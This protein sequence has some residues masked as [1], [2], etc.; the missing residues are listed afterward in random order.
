M[1][2]PERTRFKTA[3]TIVFDPAIW[4][5][6]NYF[7]FADPNP[8]EIF[9]DD[10]IR[11]LICEPRY[12]GHSSEFY[13]VAEH[14]L[15]CLDLARRDGLSEDLQRLALM[16]DAHEAYVKDIPSPLKS[17]LPDYQRIEAKVW[18]AV[19]FRFGLPEQVP[20]IIHHIDRVA[21]AT[22]KRELMGDCPDDWCVLDGIDPDPRSL[23]DIHAYGW[24]DQAFRQA[25]DDL[26]IA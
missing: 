10:I 14:S 5:R 25:C 23:K 15:H 4:V 2:T 18:A 12:A 1:H 3:R 8:D 6:G 22:E 19:A 16:H 7:D 21:L 20:D 26:G 17:L 13:S 24:P 11:A 9:L